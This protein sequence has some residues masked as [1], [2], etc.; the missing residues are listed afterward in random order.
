MMMSRLATPSEVGIPTAMPVLPS[1]VACLSAIVTPRMC[2]AALYR[3]TRRS[4]GTTPVRRPSAIVTNASLSGNLPE[5]V[6]GFGE[7]SPCGR[8]GCEFRDLI[9][10]PLCGAL[11]T[12][13][14]EKGRCQGAAT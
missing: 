4:A 2:A 13:I 8:L 10:L 12:L 1:T 3:A 14:L 5:V 11:D 6:G 9:C 7:R